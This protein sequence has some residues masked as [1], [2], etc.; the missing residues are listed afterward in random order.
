MRFTFESLAQTPDSVFVLAGVFFFFFF[1]FFF[2]RCDMLCY[3]GWKCYIMLLYFMFLY[4]VDNVAVFFLKNIWYIDTVPF[5]TSWCNMEWK[6]HDVAKTSIHVE[7]QWWIIMLCGSLLYVSSLDLWISVCKPDHFRWLFNGS[8][9]DWPPN[10]YSKHEKTNIYFLFQKP[11]S[12]LCIIYRIH[13]CA[14]N[15]FF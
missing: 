11:Q 13:L 8:G 2:W 14:T 6:H 15:I 10:K 5:D 12:I 1:F 7:T 4:V 3:G 9:F